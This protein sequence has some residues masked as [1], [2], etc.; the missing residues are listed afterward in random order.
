MVYQVVHL[1]GVGVGIGIGSRLKVVLSILRTIG[2]S[3][4][5]RLYPLQKVVGVRIVLPS[6]FRAQ[7]LQR[8][9]GGA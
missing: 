3:V 1:E 7:L 6:E 5:Q 9:K 4:V 8:S 2:L